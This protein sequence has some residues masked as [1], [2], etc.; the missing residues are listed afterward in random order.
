MRGLSD[1]WLRFQESCRLTEES[2]LHLVAHLAA[3]SSRALLSPYLLIA[4]PDLARAKAMMPAID[5]SAARLV[6][7]LRPRC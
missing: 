6:E 1:T 4:T 5:Y 2:M 7:D 3:M